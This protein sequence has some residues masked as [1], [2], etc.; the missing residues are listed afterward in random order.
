LLLGVWSFAT[1]AEEGREP[2]TIGVINQAWAANHP[3]VEGLKAGLRARGLAEGRDVVFN[4]RFTEG[5]PAATSTAAKALVAAAVDVMF[6]SNEAA[7]NAALAATR[8]IP[9]VFTLVADPVA[10]G[11]V[12][13]LSRPGGNVTGVSSLGTELVAKRLEIL[14]MVAPSVRRVWAIHRAGDPSSL[15]A[16]E[17]ARHVLDALRLELVSSPVRSPGE[18]A[19]VLQ[20][21]PRG[22]ALLPPSVATLD[23]PAHVLDAS[24][25]VPRP[26]VFASALWVRYGALVSYGSDYFAE[27]FQAARLVAKI[28]EGAPTRDLPVESASRI[29][30]AVNLKSARALGLEIPRAVLYR[31]NEVVD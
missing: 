9:I 30:V 27:G 10:A 12:D 4:I 20:S 24:L 19:A 26:V 22:D 21:V 2:W 28:L 18:V 16:I 17:E 5:D 1:G 7:T 11:I 3:A 13:K 31:A 8:R 29:E 25:A 15:A 23:I 14:K 6:T